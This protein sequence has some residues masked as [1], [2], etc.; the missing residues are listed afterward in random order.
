MVIAAWLVE[1]AISYVEELL[2]YEVTEIVTMEDLGIERVKIG[3]D[4]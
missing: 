2:S 1:R 4:F 3:P